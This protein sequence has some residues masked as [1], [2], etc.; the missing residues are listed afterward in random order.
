MSGRP[1]LVDE[2]VLT[3]VQISRA[4]NCFDPADTDEA[5]WDRYLRALALEGL[6]GEILRR[7]T[8]ITIGPELEPETPGRLLAVN[9]LATQLLCST[10][11]SETIAVDLS[12][13]CQEATAP[14]ILLV[15]QVEEDNGVVRVA[16]VMDG[17]TLV[18]HISR[19]GQA[20]SAATVEIPMTAFR[21]GFEQFL[22]WATMLPPSALPR[23]AVSAGSKASP[24]AMAI[25]PALQELQA[26]IQEWLKHQLQEAPAPIPLLVAGARSADRAEV[27]LVNPRV[28]LDAEGNHVAVV[29]SRTPTIWADRP[30]A[31]IL[32]ERD[33]VP[34]W[35]QLA[36]SKEPIEGAIGWSL[37]P[38]NAGESCTLKLRPYGTSG[39]AYAKVML[40][41]TE[42]EVIDQCEAWLCR[43]DSV[44]ELFT[45]EGIGMGRDA[46]IRLAE[47]I[48]TRLRLK[49]G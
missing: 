43:G 10:E 16:G 34:V 14:Q 26:Q 28:D 5:A 35:Q 30:L 1:L 45:T 6:K 29:V 38:L 33:G 25:G 40:V 2:V 7:Q 31:E 41:V 12:P 47:E 8:A 23:V 3:E 42:S 27:F 39:G 44:Q 46:T 4:A 15:M 21:G 48:A 37:E 20:L 22:R 24:L 32:I 18:A 9:G 11:M 49:H 36:T 17:P 19:E 13:W